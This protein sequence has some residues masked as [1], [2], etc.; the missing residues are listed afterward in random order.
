MKIKL[1]SFL[2]LFIL[3]SHLTVQAQAPSTQQNQT[4]PTTEEPKES[5]PG[6][7]GL[8]F[9]LL[10]GSD[11]AGISLGKCISKNG[12]MY[13]QVAGTHAP[14]VLSKIPYAFSGQD[15][16]ID[17]DIKLGSI[18]AVL[19]Y[20]P[21]GNAFKI[22]A[23]AAYMLTNITATAILKDSTKQGDIMISPTEVGDI[24]FGVSTNPICPYVGIGFGRAVPKNRVGFN[25]ELGGYYIQ[26]PVLNFKT[27][28]M[29]EPTSSQEGL[30]RRNMSGF[31]WLPN[32]RMGLIFKLG[33]LN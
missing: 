23:G 11:G 5:K 6:T 3:G 15:V 31:T 9:G 20:H 29:L 27:T 32:I 10:F 16:I 14:I 21:F 33:K 26:K 7:R 2:A 12:K 22:S 8:G 30:L 25:F 28:G 13:I 18:S 24:Q 1:Y 4:K 19:E 17:A